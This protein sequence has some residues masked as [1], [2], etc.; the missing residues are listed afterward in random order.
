[1]ET[2]FSLGGENLTALF[3]VTFTY[4]T[5]ALVSSYWPALN[6]SGLRLTAMSF[7]SEMRVEF[8]G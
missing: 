1:M 6:F 5:G 3:L 2:L 7:I 4:T 8:S